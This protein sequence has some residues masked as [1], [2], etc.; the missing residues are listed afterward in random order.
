MAA[1]ANPILD[2]KHTRKNESVPV[3]ELE[4]L[5]SAL[6]PHR[7]K[8]SDQASGRAFTNK[9]GLHPGAMST[10]H[11]LDVPPFLATAKEP[12]MEYRRMGNVQRVLDDR[13]HPGHARKAAAKHEAWGQT[14]YYHEYREGGHSVGSDHEEDAKRAALLLAYLNR[15]IGTG[16]Q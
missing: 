16:A 8:P 1:R 3:L 2:L 4:I 13:V 15:E 7:E 11:N 6:A 14:F 9:L 5:N 12:S 10:H